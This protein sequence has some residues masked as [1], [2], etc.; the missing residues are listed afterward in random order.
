[1]AKVP[2]GV[3]ELLRVE[4]VGPKTAALAWKKL[5][6]Q[7]LD[8]FEAACRDGTLQRLPRMG[9]KRAAGLLSAVERY[10]ARRG[11]V[12]LH[13]ALS[14]AEALVGRLRKVPGV[15]AAEVAGS[16]RRRKPT[17]GD[18]NLLVAAVNAEPAVRAFSHAPE[19][20]EVI[21]TGPTKCS[22]RL[23]SG[24]QADL[25]V[26]PPESFGAALHYFTGSKSHNIELRLRALRRGLKLSEY[27]VFDRKGTRLGGATEQEIFDAVGLPFIPP[28]AAR[29]RGGDPGGRGAP[30]A[31]PR[32]GARRAWAICTC[33]PTPRPTG[34]SPL[35]E[36][37][38][39]GAR[40][41]RR[42]LAITDH[43]RSRPLGLDGPATRRHGEEVHRL[44]GRS[45]NG[46]Q[47]LAGAEVDI[48]PDGSLDLPADVLGRARLGG[49]ERAL[50]LQ[51]HAGDR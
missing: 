43:T 8:A 1:M 22:V 48:L 30:A 17:I 35:D 33:T 50:A 7:T 26:L 20:K 39:E 6:L 32:R 31:A 44:G 28:G 19:V 27:G 38:A 9:E 4:G 36:L 25:R 21:A 16:V 15:R 49:G 51:R 46:T 47:L 37:R 14:T 2:P 10:R 45:K 42:Y 18:I 13:H 5:K 3:L 23:V 41:G 11:R 29:G 12:P 24:L 40:L 34:S